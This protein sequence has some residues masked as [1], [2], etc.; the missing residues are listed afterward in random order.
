MGRQQARSVRKQ[1]SEQVWPDLV[2]PVKKKEGK[3]RIRMRE[4]SSGVWIVF[5]C[6]GDMI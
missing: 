4:G 3:R 1:A 6:D 2:V 5:L